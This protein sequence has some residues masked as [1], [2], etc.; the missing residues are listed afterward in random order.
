MTGN[1]IRIL[2]NFKYLNPI[3]YD[4]FKILIE[5][6]PKIIDNKTMVLVIDPITYFYRLN[7]NL[8]NWFGLKRDLIKI[9][10]KF[11]GI[12]VKNH[13]IIILVNQIKGHEMKLEAVCQDILELYS[14]YSLLFEN[15]NGL[16]ITLRKLRNIKLNKKFKFKISNNGLSD[17]STKIGID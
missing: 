7:V 1:N 8:N 13:L 12:S 9:L 2:R 16:T 14:K 15:K 10:G 6:I 17:F 3:N 11:I 5:N 4:E